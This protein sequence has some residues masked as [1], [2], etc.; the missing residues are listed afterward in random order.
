MF[1]SLSFF[2]IFNI[3]FYFIHNS[4]NQIFRQCYDNYNKIIF[5]YKY[6]YNNM[7]FFVTIN[8]LQIEIL[9]F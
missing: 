1:L 6:I 7:V 8:R 4:C 3:V 5:L 9:N 2:F